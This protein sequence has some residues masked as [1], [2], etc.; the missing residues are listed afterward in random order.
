MYCF[1]LFLYLS[2]L[3]G[4]CTSER[5]G[6]VHDHHLLQFSLLA[7]SSAIKEQQRAIWMIV[8]FLKPLWC[9]C[10]P[11]IMLQCIFCKHSVMM[12]T[13]R[14]H[15]TT[16]WCCWPRITYTVGDP[17]NNQQ[18]HLNDCPRTTYIFSQVYMMW[19]FSHY[20][21]RVYW[22]SWVYHWMITLFILG[23][24]YTC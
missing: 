15:V 18:N 2:F 14:I 6:F 16:E 13:P 20:H 10:F 4:W 5:N 24:R 1:H 7:C 12:F 22:V 19:L 3:L 23:C 9:D 11:I 17:A 21:A 8:L